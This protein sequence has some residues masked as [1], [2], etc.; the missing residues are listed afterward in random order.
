MRKTN[1]YISRSYGLTDESKGI[2]RSYGLTAESQ[3]IN[4]W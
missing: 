3:H 2:S 1:V 4:L